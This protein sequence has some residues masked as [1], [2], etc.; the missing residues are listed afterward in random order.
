MSMDSTLLYIFDEL[1]CWDVLYFDKEG[2][3][4]RPT[5]AD[6]CCGVIYQKSMYLYGGL[7]YKKQYE[8]PTT[9]FW[10]LQISP[11]GHHSHYSKEQLIGE[12][13]PGAR[14]GAGA[15]VWKDCL[16]IHGGSIEGDLDWY[17]IKLPRT[18]GDVNCS[19]KELCRDVING[20]KN[21]MRF[22]LQ[23]L[24]RVPQDLLDFLASW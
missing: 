7:I 15:V 12:H 3:N 24:Q 11:S 9:Q 20:E 14:F 10:R 1:Y 17:R 22:G 8:K 13:L 23:E 6:E 19:L 2:E 18:S 16:W 21:R 4:P 5:H